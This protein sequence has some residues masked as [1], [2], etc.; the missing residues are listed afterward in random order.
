MRLPSTK[1]VWFGRVA[2][3]TTSTTV[4]F[5]MASVAASCIV[6]DLGVA[7]LL[8]PRTSNAVTHICV[9]FFLITGFP[10]I[11]ESR[12]Y[13]QAMLK[14]H[15]PDSAVSMANRQNDDARAPFQI[16]AAS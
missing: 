14:N 6:P 2:P 4:V 12:E 5:V 3:D 15:H 1:T 16:T 11:S 8:T 9:V 10:G 7:Q 13:L